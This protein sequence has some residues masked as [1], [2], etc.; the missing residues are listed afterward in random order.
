MH[1]QIYNILLIFSAIYA[2]C[3]KEAIRESKV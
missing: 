1:L 3:G 2:S